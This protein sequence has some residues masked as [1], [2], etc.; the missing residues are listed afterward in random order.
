[1]KGRFVETSFIDDKPAL[2]RERQGKSC[3]ECGSEMK[4]VERL[5]EGNSVFTWYECGQ[6][7]CDGKW[8]QKTRQK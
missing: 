5:S 1:M 6:A 7:H 3:P 2:V 8:L 4:Q